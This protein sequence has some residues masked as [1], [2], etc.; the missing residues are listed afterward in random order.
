MQTCFGV[1]ASADGHA[2]RTELEQRGGRAELRTRAWASPAG[3][4]RSVQDPSIPVDRDH[5]GR[6]VGQVVYLERDRYDRI[7][8]VAHVRDDVGPVTLVEVGDEVVPVETEMYWS[9]SVLQD[10]QN[11]DLLL[12]SAALTCSMP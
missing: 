9:A 11:D 6:A 12:R 2:Y 1:L 3:R 8:A 5:D 10:D 7:H 4:Y